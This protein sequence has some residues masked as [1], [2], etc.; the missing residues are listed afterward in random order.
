MI[1][2]HRWPINI[3]VFIIAPR[4]IGSSFVGAVPLKQA[5]T[6]ASQSDSS[7]EFGDTHNESSTIIHDNPFDFHQNFS[8]AAGFASNNNYVHPQDSLFHSGN[9]ITSN[10]VLAQSSQPPVPLAYPH[11]FFNTQNGQGPKDPNQAVSLWPYRKHRPA[12]GT[13]DLEP[14]DG[15]K[16]LKEVQ[17]MRERLR[18]HIEQAFMKDARM[19]ASVWKL[20]DPRTNQTPHTP[21]DFVRALAALK[22]VEGSLENERIVYMVCHHFHHQREWLSNAVDAWC[23][24]ENIKIEYP[25]QP[26]V[27]AGV[28]KRSSPSNRGGFGVYART[29]KSDMVKQLMRNMLTQ[30][31]W[32]IAT[33]DNTKQCK[34][35]K[36][37]AITIRIEQAL[38]D[39]TCYVVTEDASAKKAAGKIRD[40][41]SATMGSSADNPIEVDRFVGIGAHICSNLG[42]TVSEEMLQ[43][44]FSNY[45]PPQ[46]DVVGLQIGTGFKSPGGDMSDLTIDAAPAAANPSTNAAGTTVITTA[47]QICS[48]GTTSNN[49]AAHTFSAGMTTSSNTAAPASTA[50]SNQFPASG[51]DAQWQMQT[52]GVAS[53]LLVGG[54]PV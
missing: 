50:V 22:R 49:T 9:S 48:A 13:V 51:S 12:Y 39:H 15:M 47:A 23:R 2:H 25:S 33:K 26:K 43:Q 21:K 54:T 24:D 17:G 38:T 1:T 40:A 14:A 7:T 18:S 30:S 5:S 41:G 53:T 11:D 6:M 4:L 45:N 46:S 20:K 29:C 32:S 27:V 3:I 10:S 28:R 52:A 31:G 36:Y 19:M 8:Q 16:M 42:V 37:E 34:G 35:K 44:M